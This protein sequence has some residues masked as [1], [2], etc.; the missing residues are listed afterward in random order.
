MTPFSSLN[1]SIFHYCIRPRSL[2]KALKA[3]KV[4]KGARTCRR[5]KPGVGFVL[6]SLGGF[7]PPVPPGLRPPPSAGPP[8]G[9]SALRASGRVSKCPTAPQ[10]TAARKNET[11]TPNLKPNTTA[12]KPLGCP[13]TAAL[14][15]RVTNVVRNEGTAGVQKTARLAAGTRL[16]AQKTR[17]NRQ[18]AT[19]ARRSPCAIEAQRQLVANMVKVSGFERI[20]HLLA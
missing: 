11:P 18:P 20:R 2:R 10:K 12:E 13:Q 15:R 17:G 8:T 1:A 4:L 19:L 16:L 5:H 7:R 14:N 9:L 3:V 6:R